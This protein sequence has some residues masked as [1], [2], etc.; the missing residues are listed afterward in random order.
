[1]EIT[2]L[3]GTEASHFLPAATGFVGFEVNDRQ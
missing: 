2:W 1:M 3:S